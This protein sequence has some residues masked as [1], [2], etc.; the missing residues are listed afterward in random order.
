MVVVEQVCAL[1]LNQVLQLENA[2]VMIV[3]LATIA[4]SSVVLLIALLQAPVCLVERA[5]ATQVTLVQRVKPSSCVPTTVPLIMVLVTWLRASLCLL[6]TQTPTL[7][8][9]LVAALL[10]GLVPRVTIL[11]V[12]ATATAV[13]RVS[14]V[15]VFATMVILASNAKSLV[16]TSVHVMVNAFLGHAS[17]ILVGKVTIATNQ[18]SVP[19]MV[20]L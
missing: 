6:T 9:V 17:A 18:R 1:P 12:P 16:P 3:L 10:V 15:C 19:E 8:K 13:E 5:A 20:P 11:D 4:K 7:V 2:N 14:K